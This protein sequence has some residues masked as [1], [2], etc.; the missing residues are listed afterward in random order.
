LW[1]TKVINA[2]VQQ[3]LVKAQKYILGSVPL[4]ADPIETDTPDF[5]I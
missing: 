1:T 5:S 3:M 4:A 2:K